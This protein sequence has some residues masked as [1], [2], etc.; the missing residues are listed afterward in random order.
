MKEKANSKKEEK[1]T[2]QDPRKLRRGRQMRIIWSERIDRQN[3]ERKKKTREE[4]RRKKSR[5]KER[6]NKDIRKKGETK[7]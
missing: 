7:T 4:L 5:R 1:K 2:H 3:T 6:R